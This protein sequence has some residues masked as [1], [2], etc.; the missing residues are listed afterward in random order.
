MRNK[1]FMMLPLIGLMGIIGLN[2]S[3]CFHLRTKELIP[4][5]LRTMSVT[6]DNVYD[7]ITANLIRRL[8]AAGIETN[9]KNNTRPES[10]SPIQVRLKN[11]KN[12]TDV[13]VIFDSL[14]GTVYSYK[15]SVQIELSC[16]SG[17]NILSTR[18]SAKEDIL[19]NINQISPPVF[20]P[21]MRRALTQQL[22]DSIINLITSKRVDNEVIS[23]CH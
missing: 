10:K 18:L 14:Q 12:T 13:P 3:G 15:I 20:T 5:H 11:S 23:R 16:A 8:Q 17:N 6:S 22:I 4:E 9:T 2:L 1:R 19:H 7:E 21:L